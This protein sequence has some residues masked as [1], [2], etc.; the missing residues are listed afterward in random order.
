MEINMT[1]P[2]TSGIPLCLGGSVFGWTIDQGTSFSVLDAYYAAGGR[3][4]D[5]AEC[6]SSW[7]PGNQGGESETIIGAWME[8]RGVRADM[9]IATK[10]NVE[11]AAGG[12]APDRVARQLDASLE[13]LRSDYVDLYYAHR[14]DP[15]TPQGEVA[16]GLDALVKAGKVRSLGASNF[17]DAR[18]DS[19]IAAAARAGLEPYSAMQDEYNLVERGHYESAMAPLGARHNVIA[20]PYYGLAA[21][22]LTGKYRKDADFNS[23]TRGKDVR[24]YHDASGQAVIAAMDRIAAETGASHA[25]IALAWLGS[26]PSVAAPIASATSVEQLDQLLAATRLYLSPDHLT[27]LEM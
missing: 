5:T 27:A 8:A 25:A 3:M 13:R 10:T 17:T 11:A 7:V 14:D 9:R 18:L 24:R 15:E 26:R 4:I 1:H 20:F 19:A 6:Y 2:A 16:H 22:Y 23:G 21:G 12:L